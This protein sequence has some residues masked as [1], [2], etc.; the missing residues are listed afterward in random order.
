MSTEEIERMVRNVAHDE[1][2]LIIHD[3]FKE[4]RAFIDGL[5]ESSR[6]NAEMYDKHLTSLEKAR[7]EAQKNLTELISTLKDI[8][9]LEERRREDVKELTQSYRAELQSAKSMYH[10]KDEAYTRLAERFSGTSTE[11]NITK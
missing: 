1:M 4:T 7:D 8:T 10:A 3:M 2:A 6:R 5:A 9:A 11:V